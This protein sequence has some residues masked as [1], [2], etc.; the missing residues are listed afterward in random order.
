MLN[1]NQLNESLRE[2]WDTFTSHIQAALHQPQHPFR[3]MCLATVSPITNA[4]TAH[5]YPHAEARIL[6][7]RAFDTEHLTLSFYTDIRSSK[8]EHLRYTPSV[9]ALFYDSHANYQLR[10][11]GTVSPSTLQRRK[12]IWSTLSSHHRKLYATLHSPGSRHNSLDHAN[13]MLDEAQAFT[14]FMIYD[15]Q[16]EKIESL[17]LST[18]RMQRTLF[19]CAR[20]T[21]SA[22]NMPQKVDP[23]HLAL[24]HSLRCNESFSHILIT[25]IYLTP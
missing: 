6:I 21:T 11:Q 4:D 20:H 13:A 12:E 16:I 3:S 10:I 9:T 1:L 23:N 17:Q 8:N 14:H 5:I 15:I 19:T 2:I 7:V 22:Q 18:P 24:D 25:G